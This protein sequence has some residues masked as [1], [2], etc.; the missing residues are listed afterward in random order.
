MQKFHSNGKLLLTGEYVVLDGATAL[1]IPTK[2]GQSLEISDSKKEG[3]HWKSFDEKGTVWFENFFHL[4]NFGSKNQQDELSNTLSKILIEAKK[5]N[6][7]FLLNSDGIL[8]ETKLGFPRNWGLGTSS[9]LISNIAQWAEVDGFA[10]LANS[11]GGSGYDIA[12][13]QSNTPILYELNHG[14]PHFRN[15]KLPLDFTDFLFF[16]H[17]NKKQDSKEGIAHYRNA[18]VK[19]KDIQ[20]ISDISNKLLACDSLSDFEKLMDAHEETISEII[21]LPTIKSQLFSDY[22]RTIKSLGAWGGDFVL[23]TGDVSDMDYFR[24]KGFKTVIPFDEMILK[25]AP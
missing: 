7:D 3:V 24:K 18:L 9:T 10:L 17:L 8:A 1:A 22:P 15:I 11:F 5:L 16:V 13:A 14:K 25:T 20:R 12:A 2:Y 6:P 4:K 19:E 23:V 21:N